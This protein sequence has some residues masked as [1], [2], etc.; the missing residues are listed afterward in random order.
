[1]VEI[2]KCF[3]KAT[4]KNDI[5]A[6]W[7]LFYRE[8]FG[9]TVDLSKLKLP[10]SREGFDRGIV[11]AGGLT[12]N[13]VYATCE[14]HFPCSS[15]HKDLDASIPKSDRVSTETY[16]ICVRDRIEADEELKNLSAD[17]LDSK[18]MKGETLLERMLHELKYFLE[19][20]KHLD[21]ENWTLCN[22]SRSSIGDV[23]GAYWRSGHFRV[24]WYYRDYR[25]PNLRSREVVTL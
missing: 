9:L 16:A 18:K 14:K 22:G 7:E 25:N 24:D 5:V 6:S 4:V 1:M 15:C 8:I 20:G 17:N 19:T 11:V 2:R 21:L 10:P 23:P 13:Q 12:L 3:P